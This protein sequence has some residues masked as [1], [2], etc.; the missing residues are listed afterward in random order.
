LRGRG[1]AGFPAGR[2][3]LTVAAN[4]LGGPPATVVVNG[5]EGEPGTFK[6]RSILRHSPYQV[7]EGAFIAARA[8]HA[9][10]VIIALKR[11]FA[12]EVERTR[13]ALAEMRA[14]RVLPASIGAAVFEGPDEYLYG[15]ESALE[16]IDGRGPFPRI[17]PPYR[18]GLLG[19]DPHSRIGA[20]PA[21]VNNVETIANVPN[22]V[23]RGADWFRSI[24]TPDSPGTVVCTVTGDVHR[25]G[26]HGVDP[27]T[28]T[29]QEFLAERLWSSQP[30]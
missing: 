2:K 12:V 26:V 1:G 13:Q 8:V 24:G 15:E 23:A 7:I 22:I 18:V 21:L 5:A 3:W 4:A 20:G 6:D 9:D 11:S 29:H 16:T 28:A 25:H 30:P 19:D 10:R 27:K 14:A 17:V